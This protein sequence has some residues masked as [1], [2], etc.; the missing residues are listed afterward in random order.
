METGSRK[1]H[2][3]LQEVGVS[4]SHVARKVKQVVTWSKVSGGPVLAKGQ[5]DLVSEIVWEKV[6]KS[7]ELAGVEAVWCGHGWANRVHE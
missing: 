1:E 4:L 5:K 6:L 3:K 7:H 2:L